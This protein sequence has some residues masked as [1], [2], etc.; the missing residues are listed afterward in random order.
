MP[1]TIGDAVP[2][3]HTPNSYEVEVTAMFGD[4]DGYE[5]VMVGPFPE[6]AAD[7]EK[8][9][10]SLIE[11]LLRMEAAYP[12]GRGG[13]DVDADTY[14]HVKGFEAWF[15][16][17]RADTEESYTAESRSGFPYEVFLQDYYNDDFNTYPDWPR[18]P[19][20]YNQGSYDHY[21]IYYYDHNLVK[22]E[23]AY[24]PESE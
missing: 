23:V 10:T 11:T 19:Y 12:H 21:V 5:T 18:E 2:V 8:A 3:E 13:G 6:G 17:F 16:A 9:M 24:M 22:H 4:A 15:G 14:Y 7:T 1:F 20:A